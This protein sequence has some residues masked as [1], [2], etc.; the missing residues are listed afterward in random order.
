[1][2]KSLEKTGL[3]AVSSNENDESNQENFNI[4]LMDRI[5]TEAKQLLQANNFTLIKYIDFGCTSEVFQVMQNN[6]HYAAKIIEYRNLSLDKR[7]YLPYELM[8]LRTIEHSNII[9]LIKII[10]NINFC[11]IIILEYANGGDLIT[12]MSKQTKPDIDLAKYWFRQLMSALNYLH[13]SLKIIH[14]DIKGDNVLLCDNMAKLTDFGSAH[15]YPKCRPDTGT[16][17]YRAPELLLFHSTN[18]FNSFQTDCFSMGVLLYTLI[19]LKFPFSFGQELRTIFG[20]QQQYKN[21]WEKN[22]PLTEEIIDNL[23]LYSLLKQLLNP[24][25]AERITALQALHHPWLIDKN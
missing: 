11:T 8:V 19:T 22:W 15:I 16:M 6:V 2:V 24:D 5:S 17:E 21:I 9:K 3:Q 20:I 18:S 12:W 13:S 14:G 25:P 23:S 10:E 7:K 1:M 4:K